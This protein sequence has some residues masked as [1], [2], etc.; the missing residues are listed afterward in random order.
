MGW[1][2]WVAAYTTLSTVMSEAAASV[3]PVKKG[4]FA[5]MFG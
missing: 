1:G 5:R 3:K 2:A 4:L